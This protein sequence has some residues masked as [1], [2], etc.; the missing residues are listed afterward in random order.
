MIVEVPFL[1][2]VSVVPP[3]CRNAVP[4]IVRDTLPVKLH[5]AAAE[6]MPVAMRVVTA[7]DTPIVADDKTATPT[8]LRWDGKSL[9]A[10]WR[11]GHDEAPGPLDKAEI[12]R[13]VAAMTGTPFACIQSKPE[14]DYHSWR[15]EP[16]V[17]LEDIEGRVVADNR[18]DRVASLLEAARDHILVDGVFMTP[19]PEPVWKVDADRRWPRVEAEFAH[20]YILRDRSVRSLYRADRLDAAIDAAANGEFDCDQRGLIEVLVPEAVRLA[21]DD[22]GFIRE[23]RH[24]LADDD[25][26][27]DLSE[28]SVEQFAAY[29]AV[30]DLVRS[31]GDADTVPAGLGEA[32]QAMLA[33]VP[34]ELR[35]GENWRKKSVV[36][37]LDRWRAFHE[38]RGAAPAARTLPAPR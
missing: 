38:S 8:E 18:R 23:V 31:V 35:W 3:R 34:D 17:R 1:Y 10:P 33:T 19:S 15:Q 27:K 36:E 5:V 9:Y 2:S 25:V 12:E 29:A 37:T 20:E 14:D 11:G 21:L 24:Y 30:R 32:V 7:R 26:R 4:K 6:D 13:R 28:G 16:A 22:I